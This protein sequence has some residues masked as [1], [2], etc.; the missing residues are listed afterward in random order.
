M[1]LRVFGCGVVFYLIEDKSFVFVFGFVGD[2]IFWVI[3]G[4]SVGIFLL[5]FVG[6]NCLMFVFFGKDLFFFVMNGYRSSED[7]L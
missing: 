5:G 2:M 3:D 6:K 7:L 4:M 1:K